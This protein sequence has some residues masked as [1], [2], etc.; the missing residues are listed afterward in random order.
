MMKNGDNDA[1]NG[2]DDEREINNVVEEEDGERIRFLGGNN[3]S[4]IKKYQG[5]NSSDGG[6]TR[7]GVKIAG[8]VI[9]SGGEIETTF[10]HQFISVIEPDTKLGKGM[11]LPLQFEPNA[12]PTPKSDTV[13]LFF[14]DMEYKVYLAKL[15]S[16][17][18]SYCPELI[19]FGP[20]WSGMMDELAIQPDQFFAF[21]LVCKGGFNLTVFNKFSEALTITMWNVWA[22][23]TIGAGIQ[24]MLMSTEL[25]TKKLTLEDLKPGRIKVP[26]EVVVSHKLHGYSSMVV[27]HCHKKFVFKLL[28]RAIFEMF[29]TPTLRCMKDRSGFW[30]EQWVRFYLSED[31]TLKDEVIRFKVC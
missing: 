3:S 17:N 30:A 1:N 24:L 12:Y 31:T 18:A 9:G 8:G 6:N 2:D 15:P 14:N 16:V 20:G 25:F 7:D 27:S 11:T 21:T 29:S 23:F 5:S 28:K 4:G 26:K 19:V 22:G 13:A 10:G